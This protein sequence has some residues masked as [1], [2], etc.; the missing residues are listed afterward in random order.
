MEQ[1]K[2]E[3]NPKKPDINEIQDSKNSKENKQEDSLQSCNLSELD[4]HLSE[5]HLEKEIKRLEEKEKMTKSQIC[6]FK[7]VIIVISLIILL[8]LLL[9]YWKQHAH[10]II[11]IVKHSI[12]SLVGYK[13]PMNYIILITIYVTYI[14]ICAP[15]MSVFTI[16]LAFEMHSFWIPFTILMIAHFFSASIIY[17]LV[18]ICCKSCLRKNSKLTFFTYS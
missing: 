13:Y 14:T 11:K 17:F 2:S 9:R 7:T 3:N 1:N 16:V 6:S 5:D 12:Q 18:N 4:S 8:F 10:K 15:G